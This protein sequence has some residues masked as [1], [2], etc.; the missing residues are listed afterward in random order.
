MFNENAWALTPLLR[1]ALLVSMFARKTFQHSLFVVWRHVKRFC[2][3]SVHR[4]TDIWTDLQTDGT[5][6]ITS[7]ADAGGKKQYDISV[8]ETWYNLVAA[9]RAT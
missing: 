8:L 5:E 4:Q 2:P 9:L 7:T 1:H 6:N 3:E